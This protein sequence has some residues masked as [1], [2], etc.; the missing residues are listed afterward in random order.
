MSKTIYG[1][2]LRAVIPGGFFPSR[3][4]KRIPTVG[5]GHQ[6]IKSAAIRYLDGKLMRPKRA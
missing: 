1:R 5:D 6:E 3:R 4:R 2:V